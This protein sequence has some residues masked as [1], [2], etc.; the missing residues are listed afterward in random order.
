MR[1]K[2]HISLAKYLMRNLQ[3]DGLVQHKK[4]FML[5]SILPD[6]TPS[7][8]TR[9]HNIDETFCVLEKELYRVT[10]EFDTEKGINTYFCR[11][12][13]VITHYVADYFTFPHNAE[14]QGTLR[15]HCNYEEELK[16]MFRAYVNSEEAKVVCNEN[17]TFHTVDEICE[18]IKQMHEG[19]LKAVRA[20]K[21][22]CKYIVEL[23]YR[24]TDAVLQILELKS[25]QLQHNRPV[26]QG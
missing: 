16:H 19:Y 18:F 12:L 13:G 15:E 25:E 14:F 2:S 9:K 5:G 26:L 1:K 6:C 20:I 7:F 21:A 17:E 3:E 22:D 24:V 10:E 23:C 4:A 11:H 8:L